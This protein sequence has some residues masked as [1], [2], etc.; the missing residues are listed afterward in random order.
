MIDSK[1]SFHIKS[2]R[3]CFVSYMK[4]DSGAVQMRNDTSCHIVGIKVMFKMF[5]GVV[6]NIM[7]VRHVPM[8]RKSLLSVGALSR[9]GT[10]IIVDEERIR[11]TK[12]S[13][14]VMKGVRV[15]IY[16]LH[17]ETFL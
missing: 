17:G 6:R 16:M 9:L 12:D 7:D 3:S 14:V 1:A 10:R 8:L 15:D 4:I 13:L 11:V 2:D 5:D